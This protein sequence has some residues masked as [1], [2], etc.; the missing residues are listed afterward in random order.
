MM[1]P[2]NVFYVTCCFGLL[3][4]TTT[5][6]IGLSQTLPVGTPLLE[7]FYRR[8]QLLGRLDS[9]VSFSIRPLT[10][11]VIN[12][13]DIY[14]PNG[15]NFDSWGNMR[16]GEKGDVKVQ[17]LPVQ[18]SN[19]INSAFPY[20][21]N[22]GAMIPSAGY[23]TMVSAGI[24]AEYRFLS[25]MLRPEYV[26]AQNKD[27]QGYDGK[28]QSAWR[29]WWG[30]IGNSIDN[31]ERFGEGWYSKLL[32]GQSSVRLNFHPVSIGLSNENIWWGPGLY[33]SLMMSN[34]APGFAHL[35]LNT[36]KPVK[37][38]IGSFEGQLIAGRLEGSGFPPKT[39]GNP[40]HYENLYRPKSAD[41]RYLSGLTL[42]YQPR[43]L[44]G[45]TIGGSRAFIAY[46]EA[47][48]NKLGDYLPFFEPTNKSTYSGI[49]DSSTADEGIPRDQLIA[50][51]VRWLIPG[52]KAEAYFEYGRNDH[53]WDSRDLVVQLEHSRSY[54]FGFRKLTPLDW[55]DSDYL[56]VNLEVAQT[57]GTTED[58][59]R[60][61]PWYRHGTVRHGYTHLGQI[62]GAGIGPGSN[63]Q[64]LNA[65]WIQGMKQLGVQFQRYVHNNDF[66][67]RIS[68][69]MR[70]NWVDISM[71][72]H[73]EWDYKNFLLS[74][75]FHFVK[76]LNYQYEEVM[77]NPNANNYWRFR[78]N[79]KLNLQFQL[80]LFYRL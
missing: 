59:R 54:I 77:Q 63:L 56:S 62:L 27:Y 74:S 36:T 17:I 14:S 26:L 38:P 67:Y 46:S 10:N 58:I 57:E 37:T 69:D 29:N 19:Q 42:S 35:T 53:P 12:Q 20:G 8:E 39:M 5:S 34:T 22:D 49:S 9:T 13:H 23:Q 64:T 32:P 24:Y 60:G 71:A 21:F 65:S 25:V 75:Q 30:L 40:E 52:A 33:N 2:R 68:D 28:S 4:M 80:G 6:H 55:Y 48:G 51:F 72:F 3:L 70:R 73:A 31:P 78:G 1:M 7:D 44:P 76:A 50:F 16:F 61:G 18:W 43:W 79:D 41:W 47:L 11:A 66:F 15:G 45:L